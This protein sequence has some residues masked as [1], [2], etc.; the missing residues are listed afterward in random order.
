MKKYLLLII[1]FTNLSFSQDEIIIIDENSET[2]ELPFAIIEEIPVF[3][4][5]GEIDK[6]YRNDCFNLKIADH[7]RKNFK[8]P[9]KAVRDD[10]QGR[11]NV[12]FII[13]KEGNIGNI[14]TRGGHTVLQEEAYRIVSLIPKMK[15]GI[16][17]GK[18]VRVKY[19]L[20]INFK[21]R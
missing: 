16:Q 9:K 6:N 19:G 20:P 21:L 4:G 5:C 18:P 12:T 17:K 13:D 7:I 2:T 3:K 15:P 11:V 8:Y 10:I 1:L 14:K